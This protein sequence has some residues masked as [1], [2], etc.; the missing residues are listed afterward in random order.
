MVA[1][2]F[3][4]GAAHDG[5]RRSLP[6]P[7]REII[8]SG[9]PFHVGDEIIVEGRRSQVRDIAHMGPQRFGRSWLVGTVTGDV[10]AV[11]DDGRNFTVGSR[12]TVP[13]AA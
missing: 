7:D 11:D 4:S 5:R 1:R 9:A 10:V 3:D 8:M 2:P 13:T 12:V 6:K